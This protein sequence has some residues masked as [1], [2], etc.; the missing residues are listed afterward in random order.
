MSITDEI[1]RLKGAKS[2]LKSAIES[3]GVEVPEDTK[4]D[5]YPSLVNS[6]IPNVQPDWNQNDQ[7]EA[8]FIKNRPFYTKNLTVEILN[9]TFQFSYESGAYVYYTSA[10]YLREGT[11]YNVI[12]DGEP[13][14]TTAIRLYD[15]IVTGNLHIGESSFPDTGEPFLIMGLPEPMAYSESYNNI[16]IVTSEDDAS[17]TIKIAYDTE[18]AVKIPEKYLP[19]IPK[20]DF[21]LEAI[22]NEQDSVQVPIDVFS[23]GRFY[24]PVLYENLGDGYMTI[25]YPRNPFEAE[26][27]FFNE[28]TS[29]VD[30]SLNATP[31]TIPIFTSTAE[32]TCNRFNLEGEGIG[33]GF[34]VCGAPKAQLFRVAW[35]GK[36]YFGE[37]EVATVPAPS[38]ADTGKFLRVDGSGAPSWQSVPSAEEVSF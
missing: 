18:Q 12:W 33:D 11:H 1:S 35:D 5:G 4:L 13:Y 7:A 37:T 19:D 32:I 25:T 15:S 31:I 16:C 10:E 21:I 6:I 14:N 24:F 30:L 3:K 36:I 17:H 38:D 34:L 28:E 22:R 26:R 2:E 27:Y 23:S 29:T 8:D 20:P 9:G